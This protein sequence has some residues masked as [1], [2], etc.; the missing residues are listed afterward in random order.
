MAVADEVWM[1]ENAVY[2]ILSPEG[3]ASILWK[4]SKKAPDAARVMKVTAAD[5]YEQGVIERII[6]EPEV[7]TLETLAETASVMEEAIRQF[8]ESSAGKSGEELA[9]RRYQRFRR[10]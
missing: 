2:S 1:L 9:E 3:F 10:M 5:L 8:L 6:P 7:F 4:D